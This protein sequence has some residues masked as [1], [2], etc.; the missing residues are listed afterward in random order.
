MTGLRAEDVPERVDGPALVATA[1]ALML[2]PSN[3]SKYVRL[4]RLAALGMSIGDQDAR[5]TTP[6]TAR[7]IL[8]TEGVGGAQI[9]MLEDAYSE[10]LVRSV[11]FAGGPYL[12]S[13][14][15]GEYAVADL[16]TLIES[17][18]REGWMPRELRSA[19]YRLIRG[20]LYLS[21]ITLRRAGLKR[22]VPPSRDPGTPVDVPGAAR[23]AALTEATFFSND[24][25]DAHSSW[26][27]VLV[28]T[29]AMDPGQ[30]HHPCQHDHLDDRMYTTPFMRLSDG[31]RLVL[32][33]DLAITIRVRLLRSF[34][35]EGL[36][37]E[38]AK[39]WRQVVSRRV[40]RMLP[41]NTD[42]VELENS[43]SWTRYLVKIDDYR[44]LHLLVATDP[45]SDWNDDV[46]G[47]QETHPVL[48]RLAR[49]M[50]LELRRSYSEADDLVHIVVIDSPGR[51]GFWGVPNI[52]G[53][54]PVLIA[55]S[56]DLE[57]IL[58]LE[59]DGALGLMLFAQATHNL[60]GEAVATNILD[61]Y[62]AYSRNEKSFYF[63]DSAPSTT[64]VFQPGDGFD[65]RMRH[66]EETDRHGVALPVVGAPIV[67]VQRRYDRDAPEIY[68][69]TPNDRYIGSVVE[70]GDHCLFVTVDVSGA[71][72]L[73]IEVDLLDCVAFW[74]RECAIF[75]NAGR[76]P[77]SR[78]VEF[79]LSEP[80][81]WQT[82]SAE[83]VSGPAVKATATNDCLEL[84]F[85]G[86]F[87]ARMQE[88]ANHAERDLVV[89]LLTHL[90][91]IREADMDTVL[92]EV[93]PVGVKR[94][95]N[96][97]DGQR[98]P[99]M[100]A[101]RLPRALTRHEQVAAQILDE[102]GEQLRSAEGGGFP[103]GALMGE[104]R[105]RA[106]NAAVAYCLGLIENEVAAFDGRALVDFLI[107]QNES[108]LY[109]ARLDAKLLPSRLACF[110]EAS[111]TVAELVQ[112][113]GEIAGA[114]RANRFLIEYVAA[115]PPSGSR[116]LTSLD[117]LRLLSIAREIVEKATTSDFLRYRLADFQVSIL[118]SGRLGI[119]RDEPVVLAMDAYA[120][121]PCC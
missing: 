58:H 72:V 117:Y 114:H 9:L 73:G 15:S 62:S 14:S 16:E 35:Q 59:P 102:V 50:E 40:I 12:V 25:L 106:L 70:L 60:V 18:F 113:R 8:K 80:E 112:R 111:D 79:R 108:L 36:L 1:S 17:A 57:T 2:L 116:A 115:Q 23:L 75:A 30:L 20:L 100:L 33:L 4:H 71:G 88:D 89:A 43:A 26:L 41:S 81:A 21:D 24:E 55:R 110:G 104:D 44:D 74:I 120:T 5:P 119:S 94:M 84:E 56:S 49:L 34:E 107:A 10:V 54:D 76:L 95:M 105:V 66:F 22:G 61:E 87:A 6:S 83:V 28:D 48:G 97:F 51:G 101:A 52:E 64:T 91:E 82:Q 3:A 78:Q 27:R 77:R 7:A 69:T 32:P 93:A 45:L 118:E 103:I 11:S 99:D 90:F 47:W 96:V 109:N 29:L 63:S 98:S 38:L 13:S 85:T 42:V 19:T 92:N 65:V 46:W 86:A 67:D 31:Y 37:R 53:A 39:R 121:R 68:I